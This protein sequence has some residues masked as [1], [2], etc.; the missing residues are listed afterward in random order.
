MK[1]LLMKLSIAGIV[2]SIF[3]CL[4]W[5][6][7]AASVVFD[8]KMGENIC[9]V[10]IILSALTMLAGFVAALV[11][12]TWL[13]ALANLGSVVVSAVVAFFAV[14]LI[15]AGQHH[16]PRALAE[17]VEVLSLEDDWA[18]MVNADSTNIQILDDRLPK[19]SWWT[20]GH[21][22]YE[23]VKTGNTVRFDGYTLHEGGFSLTLRSEADTLRVSVSKADVATFAEDGSRVEHLKIRADEA[24]NRWIEV[25]VAYSPTNSNRPKAVLQR[26]DGEE[27][28]Y[29]FEGIRALLEGTYADDKGHEWIFLPDGTM[30]QQS[31]KAA[32]RYQVETFYHM[33]IAVLRLPDGKHYGIQVGRGQMT[34]LETAFDSAEECWLVPENARTLLTL[35]RTSDEKW[36]RH[37]LLTPAMCLFLDGD[38]GEM[39]SQYASLRMEKMPI[40]RLNGFL[41]EQMSYDEAAS[42]DGIQV[43]E[44]IEK[45]VDDSADGPTDE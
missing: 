17:D 16:P 1:N 40:A 30:S 24:A 34:V 22:Y 38:M 18:Q 19:G 42:E 14:I 32:S 21:F 39:F 35:E 29:E 11:G 3:F 13:L 6:G 28:D 33:P 10:I 36:F 43:E 37:Q 41:F 20:D 25:L 7:Y 45:P 8:Q 2:A 26:F 44:V 5:V 4:A 31:G 23:V 9:S 15:G 27:L 12:R